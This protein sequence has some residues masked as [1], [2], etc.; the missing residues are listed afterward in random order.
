MIR[1]LSIMATA[2]AVVGPFAEARACGYG[3]PVTIQRAF[4][5]VTYPEASHVS[6]A[7]WSA[8][9]AGLIRMPDKAL[10]E[11]TGDQRKRLQ[12][13]AFHRIRF[14]ITAFGAQIK[15]Q[16]AGMQD[17]ISMVLHE[18][19]FWSRFTPDAVVPHASG[20]G[21]DDLVVVTDEA[22]IYDI[23]KETLS[24]AEALELGVMRMYGSESQKQAF[25]ETYG[26]IGESSQE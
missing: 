21:D 5:S 25:R 15:T 2:L 1:F 23:M 14:A 9:Q 17:G 10:L 13:M 18:K 11:A 8:Q 24:V 22:V 16:T 26:F 7:I 19:V 20:P 6:G 4:L 3:N 12:T